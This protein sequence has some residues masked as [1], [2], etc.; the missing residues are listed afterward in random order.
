MFVTTF[1]LLTP[2]L[3]LGESTEIAEL[4]AE[5]EALKAKVEGLEQRLAAAEAR[6]AEPVKSAQ[7][8]PQETA[9]VTADPVIPDS[10]VHLAGYGDATYTDIDGVIEAFRKP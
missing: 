2:V 8:V 3:A 10:V 5:L 6:E 1:L 9:T 4:Q 7:V